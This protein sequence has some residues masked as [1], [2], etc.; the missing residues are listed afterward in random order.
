MTR[1]RPKLLLAEAA[2]EGV[3][4]QR[5]AD[6]EVITC[7]ARSRRLTYRVPGWRGRSGRLWRP[8]T[9]VRVKDAYLELAREML[10]VSVAWT[11]DD[12]GTI[13]EIEV[14]PREAFEVLPEPEP[15]SAGGGG[16]RSGWVVGSYTA[17]EGARSQGAGAG[18]VPRTDVPPAPGRNQ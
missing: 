2:G 14:A 11:L 7:A 5:R 3:S 6:W 10:I 16:T 4:F 9:M 13:T 18:F 17:Q 8:N 15:R 12:Q 1:H